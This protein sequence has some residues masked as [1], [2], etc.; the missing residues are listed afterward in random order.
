MEKVKLYLKETYHLTGYQA[1]QVIFFFQTILSEVS[2]MLI[3]A[4]LFHRQPGEYFFALF[5]M[6]FLRC[7]TGGLHFYT[8]WGCLFATTSY[9]ILSIW[10][11]PNI[12][13]PFIGKILLLLVSALTCYS[14]GP[15]TSKYRPDYPEKQLKQSKNITILFILLYGIVLIIF[16]Q[17]SILNVG[18]WVIILHSLQLALAKIRKKGVKE[19]D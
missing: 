1:A 6:L 13:L 7:T 15:I 10:F 3:M 14:I 9:M 12:P 17:I 11:L 2:K 8:Y 5:V 16:P 19:H 4:L 18:I